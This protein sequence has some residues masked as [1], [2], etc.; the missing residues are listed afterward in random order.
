[1]PITASPVEEGIAEGRGA[2]SRET[3]DVVPWGSGEV[4]ADALSTG[5]DCFVFHIGSANVLSCRIDRS[6][7]EP[8]RVA[9]IS[10][11]G[12]SVSSNA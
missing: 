4:G 3:T 1:L 12:K 2:P 8:A 5:A 6:T 7:H 11:T 10:H 9:H